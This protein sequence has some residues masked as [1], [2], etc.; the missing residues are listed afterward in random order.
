MKSYKAHC[1]NPDCRWVGRTHPSYRDADLDGATH[2]LMAP[3]DDDLDEHH[4]TQVQ[5]SA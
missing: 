2:E 5:E 3:P 1:Q 4:P